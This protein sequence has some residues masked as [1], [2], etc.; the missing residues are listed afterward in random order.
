[1]KHLVEF[2]PVFIEGLFSLT[3]S[4]FPSITDW[5]I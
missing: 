2:K 3:L 4:G 5:R 1:M